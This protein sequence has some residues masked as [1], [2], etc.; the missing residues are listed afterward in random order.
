M[1]MSRNMLELVGNALNITVANYAN[2]SKLEQAVRYA[3]S[4]VTT[5]SSAST[6]APSAAQVAKMSGAANV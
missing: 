3:L 2:D 1:G 4:Q 6:V 5:T